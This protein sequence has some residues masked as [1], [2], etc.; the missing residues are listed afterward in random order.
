MADSTVYPPSPEF[1]ERAHVQ[2]MEAYRE[3][4]RRAAEQPEEFWGEL[5]DRELSWFRKWSHVFGWNPPSAK[6]FAGGQINVAYNCLDRHLSTPRKNKIAILWEGEPGDQRQISYQELH[7]LVPFLPYRLFLL[8]G[9]LPQEHLV[10]LPKSP[11][12]L[13]S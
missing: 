12:R 9:P 4:Y 6:W 7:R 13:K 11:D 8:P 10:Q 1:T 2:G 5:A 3:L